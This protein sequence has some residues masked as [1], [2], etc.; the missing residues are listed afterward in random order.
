MFYGQGNLAAAVGSE[1]IDYYLVVDNIQISMPSA[2]IAFD[3]CFEVYQALHSSYPCH[4]SHSWLFTQKAL[5]EI[6]TEWDENIP[7]VAAKLSAFKKLIV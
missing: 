2:L 5:Y 6:D 1:G 4:A 3:T 7:R